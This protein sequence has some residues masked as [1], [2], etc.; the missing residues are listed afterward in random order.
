[1]FDAMLANAV[2]I[3]AASFGNLLSARR[4]VLPH[5]R[6][7]QHPACLSSP[8]AASQPYRPSPIGPPG[9]MMR[10][11]AAVVHVVDL[12]AIRPI[13]S[14]IRR[15]RVRRACRHSYRPPRADAQGREPIGCHR[16]STA[17]RFAPSPI[18][19]SSWC[20]ISP[21]RPSSLSRTPACST[22][23]A[24]RCSSRLPPPTC[25]RSSA[26]RPSIC[27]RCSIRWSS[28]PHGCV[29]PTRLVSLRN[30][31]GFSLGRELRPPPSNYDVMKGIQIVARTRLGR[32]ASDR[33]KAGPS[34]CRMFL[35][36]PEFT[37]REGSAGSVRT[38]LG[39]PLLRE[40]LPIGVIVLLTQDGAAVHR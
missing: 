31:N 30:G 39:V 5:G 29:T 22:S 37:L 21:R 17:R 26:V 38:V 12:T 28:W 20:R 15:G 40:G 10:T 23:C 27:R 19:R 4:R 7:P 13:A 33:S 36:D 18:N 14:A 32:R 11:Q 35:A 2:R 6:L 3:C 24:N 34:M 1:M 8:S 16:R 9:R 25:S